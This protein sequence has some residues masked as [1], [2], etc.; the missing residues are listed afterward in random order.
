[1]NWLPASTAVTGVPEAPVASAVTPNKQAIVNGV[2]TGLISSDDLSELTDVILQHDAT[3]DVSRAYSSPSEVTDV[4]STAPPGYDSEPTEE[5]PRE[6]APP[7]TVATA[8]TAVANAAHMTYDELK[9]EYDKVKAQLTAALNKDGG[10]RQRLKAAGDG[11]KSTPG[12]LAT[13][14]RQTV[15]GVP[16]QIVALLCFVSFILAYLFF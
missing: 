9:A 4:A 12:E 6:K 8:T 5:S 14:V 3:P 1:V 2:R 7:T 11:E 13:A 15:E 16:V 10:L